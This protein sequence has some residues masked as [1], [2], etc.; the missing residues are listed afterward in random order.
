MPSRSS[1]ALRIFSTVQILSLALAVGASAQAPPPEPSAP[2]VQEPPPPPP[3]GVWMAGSVPLKVTGSYFTR[4]EWR[5]NYDQLGVSG[6][7]FSEG[8][9]IVYR[10]RLGLGIGPID[11][12]RNHTVSLQFTPQASGVLG[13]LPS[14]IAVPA[15]GVYEGYLRVANSHFSVDAG[16]FM[17]NYGDALV[18]GNLDWHETAR[19]FDGLRARLSPGSSG[20]W[21]D[22]FYTF[23]AEGWPVRGN[24]FGAGDQHFMGLY[25][26]LGPAIKRGMALD[27]YALGLLSP[28]TQGVPIDPADPS[29]V[30]TVEGAFELTLGARV[31]DRIGAVDYRAEAGIQAGERRAAP[32]AAATNVLA[33]QADAEVG[34]SFADDRVR[35][36]LEGLY[37][38]GN[39]VGTA[40]AEGWNQLFP[41]AHKFLG[42]TDAFGARTNAASAVLHASVAPIADLKLLADVHVLARPEETVAG[43]PTGYA[44][45]EIDL[46][47]NYVLGKGLRLW[48]LYGLFVP[49]SDMYPSSTPLHY[50][51]VELRYDLK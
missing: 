29:V 22:A 34:V 2:A 23:L 10:A 15:V 28:L 51:E 19:S 33:Y 21:I 11:I 25:A 13:V 50:V 12:G 32:G 37:A 42:L 45:T 3:P 40:R 4:N 26:D 43:G 17:M 20:I 48:G 14:T 7:R 1:R 18:I 27:L 49:S 30:A 35:F 36:A 39:D 31:K 41:T 6:G 44:A 38:S 9:F 47:V 5:Q 8:D 24:T 46:A 16:R